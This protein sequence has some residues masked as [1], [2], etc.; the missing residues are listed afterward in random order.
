[1]EKEFSLASKQF[2]SSVC[3]LHTCRLLMDDLPS[4]L[5][6]FVFEEETITLHYYTLY[7]R[8]RGLDGI[9]EALY[10]LSL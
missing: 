4:P 8:W 6:A 5:F 9:Y 7:H 1:M 3:N 10:K 2:S